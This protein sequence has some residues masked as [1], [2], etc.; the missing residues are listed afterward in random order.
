MTANAPL[1][2]NLSAAGNFLVSESLAYGAGFQFDYDTNKMCIRDRT[3]DTP[4]Q[5]T[6][7]PTGRTF[8]QISI[9]CHRVH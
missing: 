6:G 3:E 5:N 2:L 8:R 1:V 9:K 7:Q 4:Q